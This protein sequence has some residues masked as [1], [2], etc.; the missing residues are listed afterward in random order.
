M[1]VVENRTRLTSVFE[2]FDNFLKPL[3]SGIALLPFFINRIIPMLGDDDDSVDGE[4]G[5]AQRQRIG[6]RRNTF[7]AV[8]GNSLPGQIAFW[9]L[10]DVNRSNIEARH[11][12]SAAPGVSHRMTVEKMLGMRMLTNLG[13]EKGDFFSRL[14][15][16][17]TNVGRAQR[18]ERGRAQ[19]S[20][21]IHFFHSSTLVRSRLSSG[22]SNTINANAI[23]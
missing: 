13:S 20:A 5:G 22:H 18:T 10:I 6:N 7:Q 15:G 3:I 17:G 1:F 4:F 16:V 8:F 12:P 2:D 11:L 19:K 21:T 14:P 9:E 23:E